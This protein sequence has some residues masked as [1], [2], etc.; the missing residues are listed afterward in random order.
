MKEQFKRM[1][2]EDKEEIRNWMKMT[3]AEKTKYVDS[4]LAK[5]EKVAIEDGDDM[6]EDI[7]A[8][9]LIIEKMKKI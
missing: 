9:R 8:D 2:E 5:G 7:I 4:K 3:D 6:T 1:S